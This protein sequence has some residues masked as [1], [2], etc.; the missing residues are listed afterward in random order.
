MGRFRQGDTHIEKA[1]ELVSLSVV[2]N[3]TRGYL[4]YYM[5]QYEKAVAQYNRT[6][7]LDPQFHR[8]RFDLGLALIALGRKAEALKT[9]ERMAR[10][11]AG[12]SANAAA[13][14]LLLRRLG[15]TEKGLLKS[16]G[17]WKT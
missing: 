2:V 8:A 4:Y 3:W 5:R 15:R 10:S 1:L 12:N 9:F 6:L 13:G 17:A 7:G 16:S 11:T 14:R